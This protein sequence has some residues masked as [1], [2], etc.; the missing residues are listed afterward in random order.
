M[1][2]YSIEDLDKAIQGYANKIWL[3]NKSSSKAK[4]IDNAVISKLWDAIRS[5]IEAKQIKIDTIASSIDSS[6]YLE[7]YLWKFLLEDSTNHHILSIVVIFVLKSIIKAPVWALIDDGSEKFHSLVKRA[8]VLSLS[9]LSRKSLLSEDL[10]ILRYLTYFFTFLIDNLH[11]EKISLEVIP[12]FSIGSWSNLEFTDRIL[13]NLPFLKQEYET[14]QKSL[15]EADKTQKADLNFKKTWLYSFLSNHQEIILQDLGTSSY[16]DQLAGTKAFVTFVISILSYLPTRKYTNVLIKELNI[17]PSLSQSLIHKDETVKNTTSSYLALFDILQNTVYF[18]IDEFSGIN[19]AGQDFANRLHLQIETLKRVAFQN[20]PQELKTLVF[21]T[22]SDLM[23]K[24]QF[25]SYFEL[26][27]SNQLEQFARKSS[28]SLRKI[29]NDRS[30]VLESLYYKYIGSIVYSKIIR[31]SSFMPTEQDL[32]ENHNLFNEETSKTDEFILSKPLYKLGSSYLSINDFLYRNYTLYRHEA[33]YQIRADIENAIRRLKVKRSN[34]SDRFYNDTLQFNGNSK[35]ALRIKPLEILEES[36]LSVESFYPEFVRAEVQLNYHKLHK[37]VMD[38][39]DSLSSNEVVFL[40]S[41]SEP[42][43]KP[44]NYLEKFGIKLLRSATV[45]ELLDGYGNQLRQPK[46]NIF[47]QNEYAEEHRGFKTDRIRRLYLN[48][49]PVSYVNDNKE[50]YKNINLIIRRKKKENTFNFVLNN[51]EKLLPAELSLLNWINKVLLNSTAVDNNSKIADKYQVLDLNNVFDSF[52]HL[53]LSFIGFDIDVP[54]NEVGTQDGMLKKRKRSRPSKSY[55]TDE[56]KPPFIVKYSP[57]DK[58]VVVYPYK[59][60]NAETIAAV[61]NNVSDKTDRYKPL[62]HF[63]PNQVKAIISGLLHGLTLIL[64]PPGTGKTDVATQIASSILNN[65][66]NEK[67]LIITHSNHALNHIFGKIKRL[68]TIPDELLLRLGHGE[69][70]LASTDNYDDNE[71]VSES[72]SRI[73]RVENIVNETEKLLQRVNRLAKSLDIEGYYGNDCATA[74][75]LYELHISRIW[76]QFLQTISKSPQLDS[77]KDH[78]PFLSFLL[79]EFGIQPACFDAKSENVSITDALLELHEYFEIIKEIFKKLQ[80]YQ[81]FEVL[82]SSK[83][84]ANYMLA[85]QAKVVAM[86]ATY[87]AMRLSDLQDAGVHFDNV[88]VE[89]AGQLTELE[90]FLPLTLSS[91]GR[92]NYLKRFVLIGDHKQNTPIVQNATLAEYSNFNQSLFETFNKLGAAVIQLSHQGRSRDSI[93]NLYKH[94]YQNNDDQGNKGA[95]TVEI[96]TLPYM[97]QG[98]SLKANPGFVKTFQLIDVDKYQSKGELEPSPNLFQNLGEAEYAVLLY[99]YFRLLGYPRDKITILT[100]YAGQKFL[101]EE[102]LKQRCG[103]SKIASDEPGKAFLFGHPR[104]STVDNFQ[105]QESDYVILSMVRTKRL[106]YIRDIRRMTVAVS[107]AKLGLYI[108]GN[109]KLF[110]SVV[111]PK[112][113]Q[114]FAKLIDNEKD[115][116]AAATNSNRLQIVTGEVYGEISRKEFDAVEKK[117]IKVLKNVEEFGEYVYNITTKRFQ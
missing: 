55:S 98:E 35:Y 88:I 63:T 26:L 70:L 36:Q 6:N 112:L 77:L 104:V 49:D 31:Q 53:K 71:D 25:K 23:D 100:M 58:K 106:G 3:N 43:K 16:V 33:C 81:P 105:G 114:M 37:P 32:T 24:N 76:K 110:K 46:R 101:I 94:V 11:H 74:Q 95:V 60:R 7:L 8:L 21:A 39:W 17:L 90:T 38:E 65:F 42:T 51:V 85:K 57:A 115:A 72:F 5:S 113:Q 30:V 116:A 40:L 59:S 73:G 66:H 29:L 14:F 103:S 87:L 93:C 86:T 54:E 28:V 91:T 18:P 99:S 56:I 83:E 12:F 109:V 69:Q 34:K 64:G 102:I 96:E 52:E 78:F 9:T 97:K 10:F 45:V 48:L 108:L 13:S 89:E 68:G 75:S 79:S 62:V 67:T 80:T 20:F 4:K 47:S 111:E 107:R 19:Q 44:K 50:D 92:S 2:D 41:I 22:P 1:P 84:K 27:D 82:K 117:N 61:S 15:Q